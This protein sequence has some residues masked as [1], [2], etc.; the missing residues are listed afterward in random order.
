MP[1]KQFLV[2]LHET[3]QPFIVRDLDDTRLLVQSDMLQ[4]IHEEVEHFI[5]SN[6]YERDAEEAAAASK[7]SRVR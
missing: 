3:K 7:A 2:H 1:L 6:T 4:F 5:D